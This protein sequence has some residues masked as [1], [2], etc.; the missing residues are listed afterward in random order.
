MFCNLD[1]ANMDFEEWVDEDAGIQEDGA[2][3]WVGPFPSTNEHLERGR[4]ETEAK[5]EAAMKAM[6]DLGHVD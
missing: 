3:I 4:R 6:K 2:Y 1:I 5:R